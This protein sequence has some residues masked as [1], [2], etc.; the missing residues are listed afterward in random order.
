[1][2]IDDELLAVPDVEY[3][4]DLTI[5]SKQIKQLIE[6]MSVFGTIITF[7]CTEEAIQ[8]YSNGDNGEMKVEIKLDEVEEYAIEEKSTIELSFMI[9]YLLQML[10]CSDIVEFVNI[11]L[12]TKYPLQ[13]YYDFGD[14]NYSRFYLA[15]Q[16]DLDY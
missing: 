16:V 8:L 11:H 3:A 10:E 5:K 7:K 1:M 15:P 4:V 14:G 12:S 2:D 9:R 6:E 13:I